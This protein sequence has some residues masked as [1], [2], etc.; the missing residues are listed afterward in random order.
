MPCYQRRRRESQ[1]NRNGKEV[2]GNMNSLTSA[3]LTG[4]HFIC[5]IIVIFHVSIK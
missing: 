5:Q 1:S 2:P 4:R 3:G